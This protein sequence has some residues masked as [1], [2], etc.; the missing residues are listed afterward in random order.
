M[1]FKK[2]YGYEPP[3]IRKPIVESAPDWIR[4]L[5]SDTVLRPYISDLDEL[6]FILAADLIELLIVQLKIDRIRAED[7]QEEVKRQLRNCD[8]Y[9]FYTFVESV[10]RKIKERN[11]A[12]IE[13][14]E[15]NQYRT[16]F[17]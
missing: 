9:E 11:D 16:T 3:K 14:I 15:N 6:G 1:I 12:W 8:W 13:K 5:Y 17:Y 7:K 2:R 10:G 4:L